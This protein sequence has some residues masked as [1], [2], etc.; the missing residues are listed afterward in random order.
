MNVSSTHT[1]PFDNIP[2]RV[3]VLVP[4]E[5][6]TPV[7]TLTDLWQLLGDPTEDVVVEFP[8]LGEVLDVIA[9]L[10]LATPLVCL[11]QI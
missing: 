7:A 9:V 10:I 11:R 8:C 3:K 1:H 5:V 2:K 4:L 6:T